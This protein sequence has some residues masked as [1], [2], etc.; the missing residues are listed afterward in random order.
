M[1]EGWTTITGKKKTG[2]KKVPTEERQVQAAA[3]TAR[4]IESRADEGALKQ[5]RVDPASIAELVK[6]RLA[7]GHTQEAADA[8][9]AMPKNTIKRIEAGQL[10]PLGGYLRAISRTLKV[11]LRLI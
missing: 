1:E 8:A 6:A 9:C 5:K 4:N 10:V 7:L 3:A 11:N 2:V